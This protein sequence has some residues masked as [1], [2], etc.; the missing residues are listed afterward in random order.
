MTSLLNQQ[1]AV[2][3]CSDNS[4][5]ALSIRGVEG[6]VGEDSDRYYLEAIF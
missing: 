3:V 6:E 4:S 2:L 5:P 1:N